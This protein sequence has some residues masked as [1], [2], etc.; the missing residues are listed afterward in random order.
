MSSCAFRSDA[1]AGG[2]TARCSNRL[3]RGPLCGLARAR[4]RPPNR[5]PRLQNCARTLRPPPVAPTQP[6]AQGHS[7]DT[8]PPFRTR[9]GP[10]QLYRHRQLR[11][12][13]RVRRLRRRPR[14][15]KRSP[16]ALLCSP[17]LTQPLP[18]AD[19]F[20]A[21]GQPRATA[22]DRGIGEG[23]D[24]A[25]RMVEA[26]AVRASRMQRMSLTSSASAARRS[27]AFRPESTCRA[28]SLLDARVSPL[29]EVPQAARRT[30]F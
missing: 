8:H 22:R 6:E 13:V 15:P 9:P 25:E 10:A 21:V 16:V 23:G 29:R 20:R 24:A 3:R 19:S 4:R 17:R 26:A 11:F 27:D 30:R 14:T 7:E 2:R 1:P 12:G 18:V 28:P 5:L